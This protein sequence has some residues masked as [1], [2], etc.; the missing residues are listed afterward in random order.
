MTSKS[1]ISK[2]GE[3]TITYGPAHSRDGQTM[4][5]ARCPAPGCNQMVG[6]YVTEEYATNCPRCKSGLTFKRIDDLTR[7]T[8]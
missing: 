5:E 3:Y 2:G 4:E 6:F 8:T 1:I 7:Q